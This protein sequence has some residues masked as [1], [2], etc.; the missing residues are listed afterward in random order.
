VTTSRKSRR[1]REA[2]ARLR[3]LR[4]ELIFDTRPTW[5]EAW[6]GVADVIAQRATCQRA[7][8]GA[9]IVTKANRIV[10]TGYNGPPARLWTRVDALDRDIEAD[11]II[12][13]PRAMKEPAELDPGYDDCITIHAEMNALM[14][15]DR[16]VREGGTLYVTGSVCF[17]CAK[18]VANSGLARVV[19]RLNREAEAHRNPQRVIDFLERSDLLVKVVETQPDGTPLPAIRGPQVKEYEEEPQ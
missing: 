10:A 7:Q 5:D 4:H 12:D 13:C 8:V 3:P 17:G 11:C 1:E 9:V 15:C 19:F 2:E 18:A 14:F 16:N 6:M